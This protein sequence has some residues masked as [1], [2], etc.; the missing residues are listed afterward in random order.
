[1]RPASLAQDFAE[2]GY[3]LV[4]GLV[5]EVRLADLRRL[6]CD[7]LALGL[8]PLEYEVEV[9]YPGAPENL[10]QAGGSTVRRLLGACSRS[11]VVRSW[12]T[13]KELKNCLMACFAAMQGDLRQSEPDCRL[14]LCQ[15][16]HNCFMTKQPGY[17]SVTLWHQDN[18]FWSFQ[19][20]NLITA[21]LALGEET[22]DNGCL[23]VLP[24]SHRL[25]LPDER[26]DAS[27][28]LRT[29]LP[30]NKALLAGAR[31]V[32][33]RPGD[34]LFFHSRL[35]HAAGRNLQGDTKFSLVF[36]YHEET[37][38]P[39]PGTRSARLPGIPLR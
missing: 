24:A 32:E 11:E 8:S 39:M 5:D 17:S 22:R 7:H 29:D 1:M 9:G 18:R 26:F 34:V 27:L 35:F 14:Y 36:T 3:A 13:G 15:A 4:P 20:P 21:W 30:E 38:Q 31:R 37:N 12:A 33:L 28:F 6:A 23:R 25:W 10:I 2:N 16:H 19:Q